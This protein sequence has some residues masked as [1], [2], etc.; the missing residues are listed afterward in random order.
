M[1]IIL[2]KQVAVLEGECTIEESEVLL[3]WFIDTPSGKINAKTLTHLHTAVLQIIMAAQ[4]KITVLPNDP[5]LA[6]MLASIC[7]TD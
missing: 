4:P 6:N 7:D 2:K 1:S 3:Q 5:A